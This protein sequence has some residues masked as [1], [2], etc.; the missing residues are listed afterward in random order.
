MCD[1][2]YMKCLQQANRLMTVRGCSRGEWRM[3]ANGHEHEN[4]PELDSGKGCTTLQIYQ[5]LLNC[6]L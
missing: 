3:T 5:K 1:S 6:A 4:V 2:V